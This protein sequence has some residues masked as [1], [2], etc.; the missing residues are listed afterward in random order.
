MSEPRVIVALDADGRAEALAFAERLDPARVRLKVGSQLFTRE[1][2]AVVRELVG[3]G[4]GVFL[5]LKF[6]DIPNTVRAAVR[7]ASELGVWM[8]NV[9]ALAGRAALEAAREAVDRAGAGT[10]VIGVTVLTSLDAEALVELGIGGTPIGHALA[11]SAAVEAAGLDGVVCSGHE[12]EV[13]RAARR[14]GFLLVSPG[15]RPRD[16]A[17]ADQRRVM[18]PGEALRLGADYLVIGRPITGATDPLAALEAI[19]TELT[20]PDAG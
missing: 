18:T 12:L 19:E 17:R 4:Y 8:L 9:H 2:P 6:H 13:L 15:V 3:R 16:A 7:A 20:P 10:R 11:L 1:G 14:P 5:D